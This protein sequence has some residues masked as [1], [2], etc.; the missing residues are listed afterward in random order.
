MIIFKYDPIL[1]CVGW[2]FT[3]PYYRSSTSKKRRNDKS[4]KKQNTERD[5]RQFTTKTTWKTLIGTKSREDKI[6]D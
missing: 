6:D 5:S 4:R 3:S 2:S 1:G